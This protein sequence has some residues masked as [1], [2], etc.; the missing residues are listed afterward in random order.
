M[1]SRDGAVPRGPP[2]RSV[3]RIRAFPTR[4]ALDRSDSDRGDSVS[5]RNLCLHNVDRAPL[6]AIVGFR[7]AATTES[8]DRLRD[9][10][11]SETIAVLIIDLDRAD[12]LDAIVEVLEIKPDLAVV[13]I[14]GSN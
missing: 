5:L 7:I 1:M 2:A 4:R 12:A 3:A 14:T 9:T 10:I 13:G 6:E 11:G 8:R